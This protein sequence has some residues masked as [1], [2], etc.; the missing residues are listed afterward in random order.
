[1]ERSVDY[2]HPDFLLELFKAQIKRREQI[3]YAYTSVDIE[4]M[5]AVINQH[6]GTNIS[7]K[8]PNKKPD[9]DSNSFFFSDVAHKKWIL[10]AVHHV[11]CKE[12]S[13]S[14]SHTPDMYDTLK[15]TINIRH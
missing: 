15:F 9:D 12:I 6:E 3:G 7:Y 13:L 10:H 8:P 2:K 1:M 14:L 5:I 4:G 11:I